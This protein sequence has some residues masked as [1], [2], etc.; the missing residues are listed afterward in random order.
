V[1]SFEDFF[2]KDLIVKIIAGNARIKIKNIAVAIIIAFT[3]A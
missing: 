2:L 1:F 3:K